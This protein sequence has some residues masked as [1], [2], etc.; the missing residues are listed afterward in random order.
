MIVD[1]H[2][3]AFPEAIAART[4]ASLSKIADT[5]PTGGGTRA[6]V[7]SQMANSGVDY[8]VVLNIV[9]RP[10]QETTI[11]NSSKTLDCIVSG[12]GNT[13]YFGSV[14]PQ[15][16]HAK[17][18]VCRIKA[19]GHKGIKIHPD[20]QKTS[21]DSK[22]YYPIFERAE[23]L[24]L[25]VV[26]HAGWDP[27]SP[28]FI[29]AP[30]DKCAK[31]LSDFPKLNMVLAHYGSMEHYDEVEEHLAGRFDNCYIDT[32][33]SSGRISPEQARRIIRAMGA[34]R[35]LFGSDF[36]W[37]TMREELIFLHSLGLDEKEEAL[38]LSGNACRLLGLK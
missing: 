15:S 35:V 25:V 6:D 21:I 34:S 38:I 18:Q 37:H 5:E 36:P 13:V 24:G 29:H 8:S 23:A 32:S 12:Q 27:L 20:Y 9:T 17:E 2:T 30:A 4:L 31:V 7:I 3:H 16:P 28:D 19:L 33:C 11:N 1:F 22:E 26:T 14:H 10:G